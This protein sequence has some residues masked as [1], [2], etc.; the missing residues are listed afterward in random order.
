[1]SKVTTTVYN[2]GYQRMK[3]FF[4]KEVGLILAVSLLP[5]FAIYLPFL[6]NIKT[7]IFLDLKESGIL[8]IVRNWDGPN[9][10]VVAKSLYDTEIVKELLFATYD[11]KYYAAHFPLYPVLIRLF[12][13]VF[14][15]FYSGLVLNLIF[16][17]LCNLLFYHLAKP[18]TKHPLLLT[19]V[20]TVFPA[21]LWVMRSIIAPETLMIFMILLS[22]WLWEQ[23]KFISSS[24]AG[25][26]G[27]F[28]KIHAVF[29]FPAYVAAMIEAA[30]KEKKRPSLAQFSIV[31]IPL[32]F[33]AI[34]V[35]YWIRLDDF[36]AFFTAE[37]SNNLHLSFPFSH[38]N[39]NNPWTNSGWLEDIVFYFIAMFTLTFTL[40]YRKERVWFYFSLFYTL[41]LIL[42][43][44]RDIARYSF[45]LAPI[46]LITFEQFFTSKAFKYA[47]FAALPALY[48]YTLN[49]IMTNQASIADWN[50]FLK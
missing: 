12:T 14:G 21:R 23:K 34:C 6:L 30:V 11:L 26:F 19:F 38:F 48:L 50:H 44:H 37:K 25:A 15:W 31:I 3:K 29:L 42:I 22:L 18:Y 4:T 32:S 36:W 20:F 39:Y 1:M 46:F 16:G 17:F 40:F 5:V 47:L 35:F 33:L 43:P 13:P 28:T 41:F 10:L 24:V 9:F 49:F 2:L 7:F 27:V 8:Q 45:Q